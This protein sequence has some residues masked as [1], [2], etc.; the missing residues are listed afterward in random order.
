[1]T[2]RSA[3]EKIAMWLVV[4]AVGLFASGC[5]NAS[6]DPFITGSHFTVWGFISPW[7][8]TQYVRVIPVRRFPE[9]I[10]RPSDPHAEIDAKVTSTDVLTGRTVQWRH[11]LRRFEDGSYGHIFSASFSVRKKSRYILRVTRSD[12]AESV[13]ETVVPSDHEVEIL[14]SEVFG[15][16]VVQTVRW[17]GVG[18]LEDMVITYCA[19]PLGIRACYD[20][21][22]GG[23]LPI[24]Y[25]QAGRR[26]GNDWEVVVNLSK[27][28]NL[29][30]RISALP[31]DLTLG[32]Y[33]LHMRI[34]VLDAGWR[35]L[36]DRDN[37]VQPGA[38]H[39]V[40]NGFGYWGSIGNSSLDWYPDA[41]GL[42]AIGVVAAPFGK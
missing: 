29:L 38:L 25:G 28:F 6:I 18:T 7:A 40:E 17:K 39:N 33:S 5:D 13:A 26:V 23:G 3:P 35:V 24:A 9:E 37:F 22:D 14:P 27:D 31:S 34:N 30:R 15:D 16:S 11:T 36:A 42:A 12:G 2:N 20:D 21:S 41:E 8:D 19:G 1:M 4:G 32:L 10:E